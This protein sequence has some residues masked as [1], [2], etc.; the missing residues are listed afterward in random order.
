MQLY[1]LLFLLV[2]QIPIKDNSFLLD[3][4]HGV[5]EKIKISLTNAYYLH[6]KWHC[7][8]FGY[9]KVRQYHTCTTE[10][11]LSGSKAHGLTE[12]V[13]H[14]LWGE[15][16][17]EMGWGGG[18]QEKRHINKLNPSVLSQM[19]IIFNSSF[20]CHHLSDTHNAH[21]FP[22]FLNNMHTSMP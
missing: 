18:G 3:L 7:M 1:I 6:A 11:T 22:F 17:K 19:T 9:R 16:L 5:R 15:N 2:L 12:F 14:P 4:S 13:W 10:W 8:N 20:L 21:H